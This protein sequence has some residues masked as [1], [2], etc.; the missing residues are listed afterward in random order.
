MAVQVLA[1]GSYLYE[2]GTSNPP[3]TPENEYTNPPT[4]AAALSSTVMGYG[5]CVDHVPSTTHGV[6]PALLSGS[7]CW[8]RSPRKGCWCGWVCWVGPQPA[9]VKLIC[10]PADRP[11]V[12]HSNC[13]KRVPVASCTPTVAEVPDWFTSPYT[14]SKLGRVFVQADLEVYVAC[15]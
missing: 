8:L 10:I 3:L 13:V 7:V 6:P 9:K 4:D 12:L 5:A 2:L 11:P 14:T 1:V 15:T